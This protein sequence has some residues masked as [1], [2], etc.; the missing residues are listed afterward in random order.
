MRSLPK[1]ERDIKQVLKLELKSIVSCGVDPSL[2]FW[3][4]SNGTGIVI[5]VKKIDLKK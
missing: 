1:I 3:F 2:P 5:E 4:K